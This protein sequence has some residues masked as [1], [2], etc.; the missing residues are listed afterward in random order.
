MIFPFVKVGPQSPKKTQDSCVPALKGAH[1][2]EGEFKSGCLCT[3]TMAATP[4]SI[5]PIKAHII[6]AQVLEWVD[7]WDKEKKKKE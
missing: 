7:M 5:I 2:P 1:E 6:T 4:D 3:K